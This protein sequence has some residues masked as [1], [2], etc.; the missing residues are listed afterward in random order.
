MKSCEICSKTT[1]IIKN[2]RKHGKVLCKK[3]YEQYQNYGK[4]LDS[5]QRT[6][7]DPNEIVLYDDYAEVVLYDALSNEVARATVDIEDVLIVS[8]HKWNLHNHGYAHSHNGGLLHKLIV[9]YDIVDHKDSNPLNNRKSNLREATYSQ[10]GIN[11][12]VSRG[13]SSY[14]GVHWMKSRSRW[15]TRIHYQGR[16]IH[17]GDFKTEAEA[18]LA[19]NKKATE[20]FGEFAYLNDVGS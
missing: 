20:L 11:S 4:H 9:D 3:H 1:G 13:S 18:A 12:E 7:A 10:N 14:K 16:T 2:S 15:R 8:G 19:Y 5:N 6:Q 17:I